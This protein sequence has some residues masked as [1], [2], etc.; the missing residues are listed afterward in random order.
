[1]KTFGCLNEI[2]E[3]LI[4]QLAMHVVVGVDERYLA[5]ERVVKERLLQLISMVTL[6][7][8][9]SRRVHTFKLVLRM[10]WR[11]KGEGLSG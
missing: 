10:R 4:G 1:M 2:G 11:S 7:V 8:V 3:D 9:V 6:E 5:R